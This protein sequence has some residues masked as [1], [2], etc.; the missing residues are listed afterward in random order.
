[1]QDTDIELQVLGAGQ[2][3]SQVYEGRCSTALLLTAAGSPLLLVDIGFGVT[4]ACLDACGALPDRI[5]VTHNHSDHAAE[6]P[7]V[8]RVERARDRR[9]AV[10]AETEVAR[11]LRQHRLAEHAERMGPDE[12]AD[13]RSADAGVR[14]PLA[15]GLEIEFVTA[16]HS[17]HC[18][19]LLLHAGERCL[20][21]YTGDSVVAEDLY[22]RIAE[23]DTRLYDARPGP[24]R[25]HAG[26]EE[27]AGRLGERDFIVSHGLPPGA[28]A[29]GLAL[30]HAGDRLRLA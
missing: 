30:L 6:L 8:L 23:A 13:W 24:S 9:L 5:A 29:D 28:G 16:R 3:A 4:R 26:F 12:L 25:W 2:G 11:R 21:G 10:Y 22:A 19:G 7:V 1:M 15:G 27:L 17:E 14:Q 20:F 18:C